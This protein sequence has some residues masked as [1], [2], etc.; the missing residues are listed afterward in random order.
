[1]PVFTVRL[2]DHPDRDAFN[3]ATAERIAEFAPDLLVLAGYM[4]ILSAR[5]IGRF[6]TINTHPSLLPAFP[7]AAAVR[8]ALAAGVRVSGVTV[9]WVDEGVDTGPIIAQRAVP[10]EPGDTE[11]TLHARIQGV[12]RGLYVATIGE[13]V[14]AGGGKAVP[15]GQRRGERGAPAS[16]EVHVQEES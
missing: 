1:V 4:K 13:I 15:A 8:E 5:V 12:E 7:G 3:A 16:A 10:V 2:Q 9:H 11:Q 6:R 14:R